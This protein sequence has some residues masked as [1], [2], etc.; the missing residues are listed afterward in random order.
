MLKTTPP[1]ALITQDNMVE[2]N[3][4]KMEVKR[5]RD[6]LYNK[7]DSVM[8]LE[9]QRLGLQK[10]IKEREEEIRVYKELQSQEVKIIEQ[11]RLR[12]R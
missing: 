11:E 5:K 1:S 12:L 6:L 4:L 10:A 9:K 8:T 2:H 7:T 3:I